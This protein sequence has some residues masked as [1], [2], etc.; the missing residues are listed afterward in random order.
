M[1]LLLWSMT[2]RIATGAIWYNTY[3]SF[4]TCKDDW[5]YTLLFIGNLVPGDMDPYTGCY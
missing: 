2:P 1:W 3:N 5:P 4:A